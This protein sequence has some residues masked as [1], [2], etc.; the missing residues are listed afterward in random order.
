MVEEGACLTAVI[1]R[2]MPCGREALESRVGKNWWEKHSGTLKVSIAPESPHK[3]GGI[4]LVGQEFS[5]M[6]SSKHPHRSA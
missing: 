5:T 4:R 6:H 1:G 2:A 3:E